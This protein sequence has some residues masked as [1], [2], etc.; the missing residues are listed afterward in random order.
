[1]IRGG[2]PVVTVGT[3]GAASEPTVTIAGVKITGG[4]TSASFG[5]AFLASA[6]ASSS[7]RRR[8]ADPPGATLTIRD[9]VIS[10]NRATPAE[11]LTRDPGGDGRARVPGR[12]VLVR[13]GERR[14]G[15]TATGR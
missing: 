3:V 4:R 1:M 15:S 9:S 7:R 8:G 5:E 13:R 14:A 12:P 6:A 2:G 10:G 11:I